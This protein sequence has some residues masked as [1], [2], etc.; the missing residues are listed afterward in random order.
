MPD[1]AHL[2][3]Q[4]THDS[5]GMKSCRAIGESLSGSDLREDIGIHRRTTVHGIDSA[6]G[7]RIQGFRDVVDPFASVQLCV[8]LLDRRPPGVDTTFFS[9][10]APDGVADYLCGI[11][12]KAAGDLTLD[13]SFHFRREIDVHGHDKISFSCAHKIYRAWI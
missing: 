3:M 7:D 8:T 1:Q 4:D 6:L 11:A 10:H 9:L 12:L 5:D 2:L 13:K